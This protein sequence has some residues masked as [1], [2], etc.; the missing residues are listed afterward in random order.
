VNALEC[1]NRLVT[2]LD[3]MIIID[4]VIPFLTDIQ[5]SSDADIIMAVLGIYAL[6]YCS[7]V[8]VLSHQSLHCLFE[9]KNVYSLESFACSR[10][11]CDAVVDSKLCTVNYQ[12]WNFFI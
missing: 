1:I 6:T 3:K 9:F 7:L 4:E 2:S 11:S 12:C 5:C 8:T 10:S